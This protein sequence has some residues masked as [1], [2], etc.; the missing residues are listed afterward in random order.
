LSGGL[1][2]E[3]RRGGEILSTFGVDTICTTATLNAAG[4]VMR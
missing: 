1:A 4:A 3:L 2:D